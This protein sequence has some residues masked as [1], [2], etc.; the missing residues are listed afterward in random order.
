MKI[1]I[2]S[3]G[4][5]PAS[6]VDPRLGRA[7]FFLVTADDGATWQVLDH[8]A[9]AASAQGAGIQTA[10]KLLDAGIEAVLTRHIG[11]KAFAVL[12]GSG[13]HMYGDAQGTVSETLEAF[14]QG[15]LT[16]LDQADVKGHWGQ[17]GR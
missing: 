4:T 6:A 3:Q 14:R 11:P 8:S 2:S 12:Q 7:S 9:T 5:T 10:Q 15:R 16:R 17:G 1:A 13:M